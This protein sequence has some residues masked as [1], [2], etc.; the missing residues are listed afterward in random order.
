MNSSIKN[1]L[2]F[3]ALVTRGHHRTFLNNQ[4]GVLLIGII[5]TIVII[6][7]ISGGLV[8]I[9]SSST[10]NPISGNFA[11]RAYYNAEAGIRYV[12]A[13]YRQDGDV[14]IFNTYADY[15]TLTLPD[16]GSVDVKATTPTAIATT[17]VSEDGTGTELKLNSQTGFPAEYGFFKI[18]TNNTTYRYKQLSG[19]ILTGIYPSIT[20]TITAGTTVQT[21]PQTTITAKG[22]YGSGLWNVT[23]M[24]TN[25]W[26]LSGAFNQ[27]NTSP[28]GETT[29]DVDN[30]GLSPWTELPAAII[31]FIIN[32]FGANA[33]QSDVL[34]WMANNGYDLY[35]GPCI[36]GWRSWSIESWGTF[37]P[38]TVDGNQ[39]IRTKVTADRFFLR[40]LPGG[41]NNF[42]Y[43]G[44]INGGHKLSYDA[45]AKIKVAGY[46]AH[47]F[48]VGLSVRTDS[49]S[50]SNFFDPVKT[51]QF[52]I[53]YAKGH[54][55]KFYL[56][57]DDEPFMVF[58]RSV[59][60][61][62]KLIAYK[63]L[64]TDEGIIDGET[65]FYDMETDPSTDGWSTWSNSSSSTSWSTAAYHSSSHSERLY[66]HYNLGG[67]PSTWVTPAFARMMRT[68]D[69]PAGVTAA[70]ISFWHKK[71]SGFSSL[72]DASLNVCT[73]SGGLQ[74]RIDW[75]QGTDGWQVLPVKSFT[76]GD[77]WQQETVRI[78][79]SQLL[80]GDLASNTKI[81]FN[82][83]TAFGTA[84]VYIDDV[85]ITAQ[86]L[87]DWATIGVRIRE[88][89][90]PRSNEFEIFYGSP[91]QSGTG[92]TSTPI[93]INRAAYAR[94]SDGTTTASWLPQS[95]I[96]TMTSAQ[97]KFTLVSS[98]P[99]TASATS[100]PWYW[101]YDSDG[102]YHNDGDYEGGTT[103]AAS[104]ARTT[105][106]NCSYTLTTGGTLEPYVIIK[107]SGT[108]CRTTDP[109]N[110]NDLHYDTS[111]I[112]E[113]G[114]HVYSPTTWNTFFDDIF[115]QLTGGKSPYNPG[116]QY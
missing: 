54:N 109:D 24:I 72:P 9:F 93:D 105:E 17:T 99:A 70:T 16:G 103:L 94:F 66:A 77:S 10:L 49:R 79:N 91:T 40:Y 74:C 108:N 2:S 107:T 60:D 48:L 98:D 1:N 61:Q 86:K 51:D 33:S 4:R 101:A 41:D 46:L 56:P 21:L 38:A 8:Y 112:D 52:G 59:G 75:P 114:L 15:Q 34:Q 115:I 36:G 26:P 68:V 97:D 57:N 55:N 89:S 104:G 81:R 80:I 83:Q 50:S 88:K 14:S 35:P 7:A 63:K 100:N 84:D 37:V 18:G 110:T 6:S 65:W 82:T 116:I 73:P 87:V 23:R 28:P 27:K 20:G 96:N 29:L 12:K 67:D 45:Q 22:T 90:S 53:S 111:C 47:N 5:V 11:Q 39:A 13:L 69:F 62:F 44:W 106:D 25:E 113:F 31:T 78:T 85:K 43:N 19:N 71:G 30:W 92:A 32:I 76:P 95:P 58:W 102:N 42:Y 3:G 64:T